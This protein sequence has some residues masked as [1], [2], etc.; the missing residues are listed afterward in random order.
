MNM[1][2]KRGPHRRATFPDMWC[3][4]GPI[5]RCAGED[6]GDCGTRLTRIF[7]HV[8]EE[9]DMCGKNTRDGSKRVGRRGER[10]GGRNTFFFSITHVPQGPRRR[11]LEV[12]GDRPGLPSELVDYATS[13]RQQQREVRV[14][15]GMA[16]ERGGVG[17]VVGVDRISS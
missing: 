17:I 2:R 11:S 16:S 5:V 14:G 8:R 6:M 15:A 7:H 10:H 1:R 9:N 13:W 12:G 4:P 3:G